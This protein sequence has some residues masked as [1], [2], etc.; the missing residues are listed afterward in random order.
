MAA[1]LTK[2]DS[3]EAGIPQKDD[4]K[5]KRAAST[6]GVM[7]INDLGKYHSLSRMPLLGGT[8]MLMLVVNIEKEGIELEIAI[9]TQK[10]NW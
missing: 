6:A 10:L 1:P 4:K 7:N 3:A 2:V 8:S 5:H 9:E